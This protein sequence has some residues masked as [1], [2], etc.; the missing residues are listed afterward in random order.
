MSAASSTKLRLLAETCPHALDYYESG[1]QGDTSIFGAG[2][3]AHAVLDAVHKR[4]NAGGGM[5]EEIARSIAASVMATLALDGRTHNGQRQPPIPLNDAKRGAE[6]ALRYL[7]MT[8]YQLPRGAH[9]EIGLA[10][11]R[12]W[13]PVPYR[14]PSAFYRGIL[15]LCGTFED[16]D[17]QVVVY[18]RDYKTAWSTG[19]EAPDTLQLRG[20]ILLLLAHA[21]HVLKVEQIDVAVREVV[22]VQS[23]AVFSAADDL[24]NY[25]GEQ[26]DLW[27]EEIGA[28]VR[29][30]ERM[31]R[32][33]PAMPGPACGRCQ[34]RRVCDA[35]D[36]VARDPES[37]ARRFAT[38]RAH[39]DHLEPLLRQ[40]TADEPMDVGGEWLGWE[41]TTRMEAHSEAGARLWELVT[42]QKPVGAER[43]LLRLLTTTGGIKDAAK[44]IYRDGSQQ[45][46]REAL[47]AE[48]TIKKPSARWGF[49]KSP[50][51]APAV[52]A[53]RPELVLV[54][55]EP[56]PEPDY[57]EPP[58][59]SE[60]LAYEPL[61]ITP[62][63]ADRLF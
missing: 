35:A 20:Q 9:P 27:R 12:N 42:G 31:K 45:E 37:Q 3:A 8:D 51:E 17:G 59:P 14:S 39:A 2:T 38:F 25:G 50:A 47:Y 23:C 16:E 55:P 34:Y 41:P 6:M 10:V 11:D 49:Y 43:T 19:P 61:E 44:L 63:L 13:K 52:S 60:T 32:P 22:S 33:R 46:Q 5:R 28:I 36:P 7:S 54:A 15:D 1:V 53:E 18:T 57:P 4:I 21:E 62:D 29:R 24:N 48:L 56:L 58:S 30:I 40:A 26:H